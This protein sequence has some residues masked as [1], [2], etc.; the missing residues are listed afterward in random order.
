MKIELWVSKDVGLDFPD[1]WNLMQKLGMEKMLGKLSEHIH[2]ING[3]PIEVRTEQIQHKETIG[4]TIRAT[5]IVRDLIDP[6]L[7]MIPKD[8]QRLDVERLSEK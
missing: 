1:Y 2:S 3:Y 6:S 4:S 5:K 8:Y 7:F